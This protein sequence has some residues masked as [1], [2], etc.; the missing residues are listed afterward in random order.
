MPQ[1]IF[2]RKGILRK[3]NLSDVGNS[4]SA[5]NNLLN[6]LSTKANGSFI[7]EDLDAIRNIWNTGLNSGQYQAFIGSAV[8]EINQNGISIPTSPLITYQNRLDKFRV[9]SGEPR[10]RGGNG[11][12]ARYFDSNQVNEN[13]PSIFSGTPYKTDNEWLQGNFNWTDKLNPSSTD[14][15]GGIEWEGFWIP[16]LTG[17]W[18]FNLS[19]QNC[20]QLQFETETHANSADNYADRTGTEFVLIQHIGITTTFAGE[21]SGSGNTLTIDTPLN[22]NNFVAIGMSASNAGTN[23]INAEATVTGINTST[24]V[25][26][27]AT[28][29]GTDSISN[30]FNNDVTFFKTMGQSTNKE[31]KTYT[32]TAFK[33]YRIKLRYFIPSGN[34]GDVNEKSLDFDRASPGSTQAEFK[35]TELYDVDYDFSEEA[36]GTFGKYLNSSILFGGGTVGLTDAGAAPSNKDDYVSVKT[37]KKIDIKYIP[38]T[39]HAQIQKRLNTYNTNVGNPIVSAGNNTNG[40]E[41]GN[42]VF[43]S[44]I[45][46][47]NNTVVKNVVTNNYILLSNNAVST[48]TNTSLE[49]IDHR[50]FVKRV[51]GTVSNGGTT[52]TFSNGNTEDLRTGMIVIAGVSTGISP[53][54]GITTSANTD[55]VTI[56]PAATAGITNGDFFFYESK[57]LRNDSLLS[58]CTIEE[59]VC[60]VAS[61]NTN[62]GSTTINVDNSSDL[63]SGTYTVLGS[64]FAS[65]T[66]ISSSNS[67]SITINNATTAALLEGEKIAVTRESSDVSERVLCCPPLDTS[68]P[69]SPTE[70]GLETPTNRSSIELDGGNLVFDSLSA[71]GITTIAALSSNIT[72]TCNSH[73]PITCNNGNFKM[74]C[75]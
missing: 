36:K 21:A 45:G 20:L 66:T 62:A 28:P 65:N 52:V 30:S 8:E 38:K 63:G 11:P 51:T 43:G 7:S 32:L 9:F 26:T 15:E 70:S 60:L 55:R 64:Q 42:R 1:K 25:I 57:G 47:D 27:L 50:G 6:G 24:G 69:Y 49:F 2:K 72:E 37:T 35:Y 68:P 22:V 41:I 19:T 74:L 56:F 71:T 18:T 23:R 46:T 61:N 33:H 44:G 39:T 17:Q 3:N 31:W 54:T 16:T 73:I 58:F 59:T 13:D 14:S 48:Q 12:T 4:I 29:D 75:D 53:F 5:L 10:L 67:T 40:I 34:A